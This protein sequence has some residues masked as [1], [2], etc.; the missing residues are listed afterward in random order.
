MA[1]TDEFHILTP[2]DSD[3]P[4]EGATKIRELKR[5]LQERLDVDHVFELD[6]NQVSDTD[7]G[8]HKKITLPAL[9]ASPS[10]IADTGI[11]FTKKIG[12]YAEVFYLDNEGNEVQLTEEGEI[13]AAGAVEIY[14]VNASSDDTAP[15]GDSTYGDLDSMIITKTFDSAGIIKVSFSFNV[16]SSSSDHVEVG[17]KITVN[18]DDKTL[19]RQRIHYGASSRAVM[20]SGIWSQEVE[21]DTEYEVKVRWA[22]VYA[23]SPTLTAKQRYLI[24][25]YFPGATG[26]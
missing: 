1:W 17:A 16:V 26:D 18:D 25:E 12:D 13:K 10:H 4:K 21:A 9:S 14:Q 11:F 23:T 22:R 5:A 8:K 20:I 3:D 24:L 6:S 7:A 15:S 2:A 19:S